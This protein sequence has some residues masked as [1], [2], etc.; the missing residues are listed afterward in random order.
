MR[1][2]YESSILLTERLFKVD[3]RYFINGGFWLSIG[4][5]ITI[6]FG[7]VSTALLAH[8][9]DEASYGVYKYLI[10]VATIITA[11]SLS[12]AGQSIL[13]TAAKGYRNFYSENTSY[14]LK[15]NLLMSVIGGAGAS[16]YYLNGNGL[17]ATGCLL[18]ALIQPFIQTYQYMPAYLQ[19]SQQF[20]LTS[21]VHFFRVIFT[22]ELILCTLLLTNNVILLFASYLAGQLVAN[23][24]TY[25]FF[26]HKDTTPTPFEITNK[27]INYAKHTSVR[28]V[29]GTIAQKVDYLLVFTQLGAVEL[30]MYSVA[31][32]IPEQIKGS[33][34]NLSQLLLPKYS[35]Q[36]NRDILISS[37]PKRSLQLSGVL[38][39]ITLVYI[40]I[41]P[42]V[43]SLL[44]P[45]YPD[46]IVLSQ[47]SALVFPAFIIM[48]PLNILHASLDERKL[49]SY[50]LTTSLVQIASSILLILS[51]GLIG[52]VLG[53][54][55]FRYFTAAYAFY[56]VKK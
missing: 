34:K 46:A 4:Q 51:M 29:I 13:Q 41:A 12:G 14:I 35:Q 23:L 15:I 43:F 36:E 54:I 10:T 26:I 33:L 50:Y 21:K 11:F 24:T 53:R 42:F 27:Y 17:L 38:I 8:Y 25:Y 9:L 45:K 22:T 30:A 48:I 49:Y 20:K 3:A 31:T 5:G 19:G 16:Y 39:L 52:A 56:L 32:V 6:L 37:M 18:I 1:R 44:F 7:L 47:L 55:I 40:A 28:G 2:L